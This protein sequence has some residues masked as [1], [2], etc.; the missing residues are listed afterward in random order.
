MDVF[1]QLSAG[2]RLIGIIS[3][4]DRLGESIPQKIRVKNGEK[5]SS[6]SLELA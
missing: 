5:G 2:N 1:Q 6:L 3:H 4:V